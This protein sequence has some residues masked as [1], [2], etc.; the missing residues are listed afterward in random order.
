MALLPRTPSSSSANQIKNIWSIHS[1][2]VHN[3][4]RYNIYRVTEQIMRA[5]FL[6]R[7]A[8]REQHRASCFYALTLRWRMKSWWFSLLAGRKK[9]NRWS[10][11]MQR[12]WIKTKWS[13]IWYVSFSWWALYFE[14]IIFSQRNWG[15]PFCTA[16]FKAKDLKRSYTLNSTR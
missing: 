8:G 7:A 13:S 11:E 14:I 10:T 1:F 2:K 6:S 15:I 4:W 9:D 16:L 12:R 5:I 3:I